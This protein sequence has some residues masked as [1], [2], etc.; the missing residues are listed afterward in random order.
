VV[1]IRKLQLVLQSAASIQHV[2]VIGIQIA[3]A[4]NVYGFK[5][6]VLVQLGITAPLHV[7]SVCTHIVTLYSTWEILLIAQF[8]AT[9][10]LELYKDRNKE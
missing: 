1:G 8:I 9:D 3:L 4:A 10:A 6:H 7:D 2:G 5:G